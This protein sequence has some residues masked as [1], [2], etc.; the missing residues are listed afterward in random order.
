MTVWMPPTGGLPLDTKRQ[1]S[2]YIKCIY[3]CAYVCV[4]GPCG[5]QF[6]NNWMRKILRTSKLDEAIGQVHFGTLMNFL[7]QHVY[8]HKFIL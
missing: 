5:V 1:I 6:G 8:Y 3:Q 7:N 2:A 4:I